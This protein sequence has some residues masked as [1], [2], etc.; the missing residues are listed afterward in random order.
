MSR[1]TPV[2]VLQALNSAAAPDNTRRLRTIIVKLLRMGNFLIIQPMIAG[3]ENRFVV[4]KVCGASQ[5]KSG[6]NQPGVLAPLY[7]KPFSNLYEAPSP[8]T[9]ASSECSWQFE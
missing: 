3:S 9:H 5:S 4:S 7:E 6:T 1:P 2:V 8:K